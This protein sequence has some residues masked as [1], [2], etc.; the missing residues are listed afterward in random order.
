MAQ[1]FRQRIAQAETMARAG[2]LG[3]QLEV[4]IY[5]AWIFQLNSL[6]MLERD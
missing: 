6:K 5:L 4:L 2:L 1:I 3:F